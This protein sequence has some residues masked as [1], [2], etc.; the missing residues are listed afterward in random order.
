MLHT[1]CFTSQANTEL[2]LPMQPKPRIRRTSSRI[3]LLK[4]II[5]IQ[6]EL[7]FLLKF[8]AT[9]SF[10]D[11]PAQKPVVYLSLWK[12]KMSETI[13]YLKDKSVLHHRSWHM[14][15]GYGYGYDCGLRHF[16]H[17]REWS[18]AL[19]SP[20]EGNSVRK[21]YKEGETFNGGHSDLID[22]IHF[23]N[24]NCKQGYLFSPLNW[25]FSKTQYL[26][27]EFFLGMKM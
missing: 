12:I 7:F 17:S 11:L 23:W 9:C 25:I 6:T 10:V 4:A 2:P 26:D 14:W 8:L 3:L 20:L 16:W 24:T 1:S 21:A 27:F 18:M 13:K 15:I 22:S 5:C 19:T